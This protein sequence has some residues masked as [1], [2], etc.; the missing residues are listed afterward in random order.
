MLHDRC[1]GFLHRT[2]G[3][4]GLRTQ[5]QKFGKNVWIFDPITITMQTWRN[6]DHAKC[7]RIPLECCTNGAHGFSKGL[8]GRQ[9]SGLKRQSLEKM[10]GFLTPL[11]LLCK[12][13]T[14]VTMQGA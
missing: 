12:L 6:S 8:L 5:T 1:T 3:S 2:A 11:P 4:V 14:T 13:G 9:D 10:S 7:D